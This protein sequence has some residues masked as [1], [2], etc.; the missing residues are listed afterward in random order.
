MLPA[1]GL[2]GVNPFVGPGVAGPRQLSGSGPER[3]HLAQRRADVD[4]S[5]HHQRRGPELIHPEA[6][7]SPAPPPPRCRTRPR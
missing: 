4:E 5:V 3:R 2:R 6:G 7:R 1:D